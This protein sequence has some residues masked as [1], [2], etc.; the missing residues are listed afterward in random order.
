MAA[1]IGFLANFSAALDLRVPILKV[2][3]KYHRFCI[4]LIPL[5]YI[6]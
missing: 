2:K 3:P 4:A 6:K 1:W 5:I